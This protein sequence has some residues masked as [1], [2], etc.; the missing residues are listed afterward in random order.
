M[1]HHLSHYERAKELCVYET[2][3][4]LPYQNVLNLNTPARNFTK[5]NYFTSDLTKWLVFIQICHVIL[6]LT[7]FH[8]ILALGKLNKY[9]VLP[10]SH[11]RDL[12]ANFCCGT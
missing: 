12:R 8:M 5:L 10:R 1:K 7:P 4:K 6:K 9:T 3:L 2:Q 11:S